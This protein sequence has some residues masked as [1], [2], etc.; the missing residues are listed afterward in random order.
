ML[1]QMCV[2]AWNSYSDYCFMMT[3]FMRTMFHLRLHPS[4]SHQSRTQEKNPRH[5]DV[6]PLSEMTY[7]WNNVLNQSTG[8]GV[9]A[10]QLYRVYLESEAFTR[11]V[12][13]AVQP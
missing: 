12:Q 5:Y 3:W 1:F 11:Y 7:G 4:G 8:L 13:V 6:L 9:K 10:I 2:M